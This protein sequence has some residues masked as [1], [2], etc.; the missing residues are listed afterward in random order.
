MSYTIC[1]P[2]IGGDPL[3]NPRRPD[4]LGEQ[5]LPLLSPPQCVDKDKLHLFY[6][7]RRGD[8]CKLGIAL[9]HTWSPPLP[10]RRPIQARDK[11]LCSN[12][13]DR[14]QIGDTYPLN[15]TRSGDMT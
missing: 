2:W 14:L 10:P 9:C 5:L 12:E 6:R 3:P 15:I 11:R 1:L 13:Y 4:A 8:M 7:A